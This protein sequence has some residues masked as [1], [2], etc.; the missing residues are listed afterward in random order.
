MTGS[1]PP[2]VLWAPYAQKGSVYPVVPVVS[3]LKQAGAEVT[4][5]GLP[6]MRGLADALGVE[7]SPYRSGITYDWSKPDGRDR[8]GLGPGQ[9]S[10][11]FHRRV[12]DEFAEVE[13]LVQ[14][15]RPDV[16]LVD[17]F[18]VGGGLAA[19][20]LATPWASYVHYLFD[21]SAETDA[22][23]R[24]WWEDGD[25]A[26]LDAYRAWWDEV[27]AGVGLG[28]ET[29]DRRE[30]PWYR[31]SPQ[32]TFMLG[33][34]RLRRG[35]RELPAFVTRTSV[36]PWDEPAPPDGAPH[37]GADD[38]GGR[39][40]VLVANSSAWQDDAD[41]VRAALEGLPDAEVVVTVS[42]EHAL[43]VEPAGNATVLPYWPHTDLLP[44][45]DAVLTTAG[46]GIVSKALWF[47]KPVVAVPHARDQHYVAEAVAAAGCGAAV[48]WP[49]KPDTVAEAVSGVLAS[50]AVADRV[51]RLSGPMAG[52]PSADDVASSVLALAKRG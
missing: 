19:E 1:R 13:R 31:M 7:F 50:P 20:S 45:V 48:P 11:W 3:A 15:L 21:E 9:G 4:L 49:P 6:R 30:A 2:R 32:Y 16:L 18:V 23:H 14:S 25:S 26:E 8:H 46:Y 37:R 22:M 41:L 40:R 47:G 33:H 42:A 51:A 10:D 34:P 5:L 39:P 24:V 43:D 17:S 36:R 38:R 29:R 27:R 35:D 44:S 52:F 28:P 12:A